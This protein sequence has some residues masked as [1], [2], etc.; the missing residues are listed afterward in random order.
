M[1][2]LHDP[3]LGQTAEGRYHIDSL[4]ADGGMATVYLATDTRLERR[5]ALKLIH[6]Q[7]AA[8]PH[9]QQFL[10]RFHMEATSAARIAD[11][12]IVQVY[13]TGMWGGLPYLVM[14]YVRG[15]DL[16][17]RLAAEGTL[18]VRESLRILTGVLEGL[19]AA[20]QAGIIHR[21][22]KP[23]NI[24][25]TTRGRV[26]ITDF[27]LAKALGQDNTGTTGLLLGTASYL[28]PE[29]V[30][31]NVSTAA[32]D[33][34]AVGIMAY[35]MLTGAVPF[36]SS[37][38]V[39]TVFRHVN[40][41]VPPVSSLDPAFAGPLSGMI[42]RLCARDPASRPSDGMA[43]L[44]LLRRTQAS[45]PDALLSYRHVPADLAGTS[46]PALL[47]SAT[48]VVHRQA[49]PSDDT[50]RPVQTGGRTG[51]P[52]PQTRPTAV[53]PVLAPPRPRSSSAR[54]HP[55]ADT[56]R[57]IERVSR[58]T[59]PLGSRSVALAANKDTGTTS[60]RRRKAFIITGT[61]LAVLAIAAVGVWWWLFGPGST[62]TV[63]KA[64]DVSCDTDVCTLTG[65]DWSSYRTRLAAEG[66]PY[67]T[68][69]A[70]SDTVAK[71]HVISASRKAG[72]KL[73]KRLGP[74]SLTL[75]KGERQATVPADLLDCSRYPRPASSLRHLGFTHVTV[76]RVWSVSASE[77]CAVSSSVRPGTT[78]GHT[79]AITL[80]VSKGRKPVTI[81]DLVGTDAD[82]AQERLTALRLTVTRKEEYSDTVTAGKVISLSPVAGS[83]AHW[84]DSV[85]M[86]ISR[87][88]Q[89]V[90]MP[91]LI[92]MSKQE[93][94][95]KLEGMGFKVEMKSS[96]I[97]ELLHQV[98][99]Q[100]SPAG[101]QVRLRDKEGNPT[102]ITLT[103]V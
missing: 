82:E 29:T 69:R 86:T 79:T 89:T 19:S 66:I 21:D 95:S 40:D 51:T 91:N 3:R 65:A 32:S 34:Y 14:E 48:P 90:T 97:G 67:T 7:L 10:H 100:S 33:I 52:R 12:H 22:I 80:T 60:S 56:T 24:L 4:I 49:G 31:D 30:Q 83:S 27:G 16:R 78:T 92:G 11:P 64:T 58:P 99:S 101:S 68:T 26:K 23:E 41:D 93:A 37:N 103:C 8:G 6:Q 38:A 77:G 35:E 72:Q 44:G 20:H 96:P 45:L 87:G 74:L 47:H 84:G 13:D 75:S 59:Q 2:E 54:V 39:T 42:D 36:A 94:R 46:S 1:A 62:Y 9:G 98:F 55:A 43:A 57:A 53:G 15:T 81:P 63:P 50:S 73:S 85:T 76:R 17:H 5:V 25:L 102:V 18:G 70:Y 28:S 88:P 71:G 61:I